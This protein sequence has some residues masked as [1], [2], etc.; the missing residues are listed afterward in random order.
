VNGDN[1]ITE[2]DRQ[3]YKKA[4]P[5]FFM[6]LTN[7]FTYKDFDFSFTFR[8]SFGGYMYNNTQSG[9][10]FSNCRYGNPTALLL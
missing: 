7:N 10:G 1:V 5:D 9:S 6:G 8:G 4:S 2:A 3:P